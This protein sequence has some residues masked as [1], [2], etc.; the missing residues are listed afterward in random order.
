MSWFLMSCR[1]IDE[2]IVSFL[3]TR[4]SASSA[5][6][7]SVISVIT[8]KNAG[9][10]L[11]SIRTVLIRQCRMVPSRSWISISLRGAGES[12]LRIASINAREASALAGVRRE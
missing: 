11:S 7:R 12:P 5:A 2:R 3:F 10:P 6:F 1:V 9:I 8:D 4:E